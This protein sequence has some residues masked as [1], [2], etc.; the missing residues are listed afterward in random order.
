[1]NVL[2][3]LKTRNVSVSTASPNRQRNPNLTHNAS[4][5]RYEEYLFLVYSRANGNT[6]LSNI[7]LS[8]LKRIN[9][10]VYIFILLFIYF[11]LFLFLIYPRGCK[12]CKYDIEDLRDNSSATITCTS[13][14]TTSVNVKIHI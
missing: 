2:L 12:A 5:I 11:Y 6:V 10:K 4:L 9:G 8:E 1:M 3:G 13:S 14:T 7:F